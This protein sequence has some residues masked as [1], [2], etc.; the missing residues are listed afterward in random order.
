MMKQ[1]MIC[2][3]IVVLLASTGILWGCCGV[4]GMS[5]KSAEDEYIEYRIYTLFP[6]V[7]EISIG[8]Q[9]DSK[10]F[11]EQSLT[12]DQYI[13]NETERIAKLEDI[14]KT[15]EEVTVPQDYQESHGYFI[16]SLNY[17]IKSC[18]YHID[19]L[20]TGNTASEVKSHEYRDLSLEYT[21]RMADAT[22]QAEDQ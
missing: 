18:Q 21:R 20:E 11:S 17:E 22:P 10:A 14:I 19:F 4:G 6:E 15:M 2:C 9:N 8:R 13:G 3:L 7:T 1:K 16:Q 5:G 12:V